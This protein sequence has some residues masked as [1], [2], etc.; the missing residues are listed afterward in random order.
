MTALILSILAIVISVASAVFTAVSAAAHR[1]TAAAEE[2]VLSIERERRLEER[3][4]RVSVVLDGRGRQRPL[5]LTLDSE[6]ALTGVD[7]E[8]IESHFYGPKLS[9]QHAGWD[10]EFNPR[11]YGVVVPRPGEP[12][13]HAYS[14]SPFTGERHGLNPH[15]SISWAVNTKDR[16]EWV[17][18]RVLC[19]GPQGE[20]W[21]LVVTVQA[22]P[23]IEDTVG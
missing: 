18:L 22:Q 11:V 4:P 2:G 10:C 16:L 13:T 5:R 3:R 19:H 7:V 14:Y 9:Q 23:R 21:S 15:E 6:E 1:R 20:Q 12:A 8:M 17:R